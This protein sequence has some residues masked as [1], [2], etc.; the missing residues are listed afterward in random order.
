[1][2]HDA[3]SEVRRGPA[4]PVTMSAEITGPISLI[5]DSATVGQ[6][7]TLREFAQA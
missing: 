6:A 5:S 2:P 1:M 4:L 3:I 7:L